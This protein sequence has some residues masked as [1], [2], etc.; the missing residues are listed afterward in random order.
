[1]KVPH[2]VATMTHDL[3]DEDQLVVYDSAGERLVVLNQIGAA[4][5]H[6]V[7]GKRTTADIASF[8]RENLPAG[9]PESCESDVEAFLDSLVSHGVVAF[10]EAEEASSPS[11]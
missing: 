8:L 3:E 1:M 4:I 2:L 10:S 11:I 7:D 6:L 9:V 5:F